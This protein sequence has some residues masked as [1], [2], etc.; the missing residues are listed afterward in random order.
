[1]MRSILTILS[2]KCSIIIKETQKIVVNQL[3]SP[4][5]T[6]KLWLRIISHHR[7][8]SENLKIL[9]SRMIARSSIGKVRTAP[10]RAGSTPKK[11][12]VA[13]GPPTIHINNSLPQPAVAIKVLLKIVWMVAKM[14]PGSE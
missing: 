6:K 2:N 7:R 1:M 9:L 13:S 11:I 4:I 5:L 3:P 10:Y 12:L 14:P 8:K